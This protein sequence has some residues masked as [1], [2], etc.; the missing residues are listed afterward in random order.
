MTL[1]LFIAAVLLALGIARYN[2]SNKL[3]WTLLTCFIL[4]IACTKVVY[5]TFSEKEQSEQ[6]LDQA[7]PTQGLLPTANAFVLFDNTV[8]YTTDVKVTSKPVGQVITPDYTEPL[9]TLSDVSGATQGSYLH[10][11]PNPPNKVELVDTS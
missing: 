1:A 9:F 10:I 8:G 4:G 6:S 11:L 7:Y 3:F 2:Q 5:D